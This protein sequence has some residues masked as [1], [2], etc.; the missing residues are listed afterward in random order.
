ML[1]KSAVH[2]SRVGFCAV[3]A[4]RSCNSRE[5]MKPAYAAFTFAEAVRFTT[6]KESTN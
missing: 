4:A 2:V 6:A 5:T 1:Q 3:Q